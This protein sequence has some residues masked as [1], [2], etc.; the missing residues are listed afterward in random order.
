[1]TYILQRISRVVCHMDDILIWGS[2]SQE[3]NETLR[4]V[5]QPHAKAGVTLNDPK[6]VFNVK[7]LIFLGHCL[8]EDEIRSG[9]KEG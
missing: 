3:H 7:R 4:N 8:D 5:R 1:M 6:C 9:E 2:N